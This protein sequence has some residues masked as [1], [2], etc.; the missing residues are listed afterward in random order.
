MMAGMVARDRA[1]PAALRPARRCCS[2]IGA[3]LGIFGWTREFASMRFFVTRN[4]Q[5]QPVIDGKCKVGKLSQGLYVMGL[6]VAFFTALL[7]GVVI[8]QE[9]RFAPVSEVALV[10]AASAVCCDAA[11]PCRSLF[12]CKHLST[13]GPRAE[14]GAFVSAIER[15]AA[16]FAL[17]WLRGVSG[18]PTLF[19]AV[20]RRV[21]TIGFDKKFFTALLAYL[22]NLRVL[23]ISIVPHN[24]QI[25]TSYV[26]VRWSVHTGRQPVLVDI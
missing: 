16:I 4:A 17:S 6:N 18:R 25:C 8:A 11:F 7:A 24:T 26:A 9:Y 13:T 12:A 15:L 1:R 20:M 5:R 23:H 2:T 22:G 19:G 10:L 21:S 3:M 14:S